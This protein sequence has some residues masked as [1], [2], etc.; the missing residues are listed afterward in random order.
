M[1]VEVTIIAEFQK[2]VRKETQCTLCT[3]ESRALV[4]AHAP[5]A[6]VCVHTYNVF[7]V[8]CAYVK[9]A[10]VPLQ[11][12]RNA[13]F[14]FLILK[15]LVATHTKMLCKTFKLR[16]Q[17]CR[18]YSKTR[19]NFYLWAIHRGFEY[20]CVSSSQP[21]LERRLFL[22]QELYPISVKQQGLHN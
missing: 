15:R 21:D 8:C 4:T 12:I 7:R 6:S 2:R 13:L 5:Y 14:A 9:P 17:G 19:A 11:S 18:R 10:S 16:V 20:V 3:R 22:L 1:M